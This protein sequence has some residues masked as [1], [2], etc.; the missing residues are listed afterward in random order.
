MLISLFG[1]STE[2]EKADLKSLVGDIEREHTTEAE[3]EKSGLE[4]T[5]ETEDEGEKDRVEEEEHRKLSLE[6]SEEEDD[7]LFGSDIEETEFEKYFDQQE[8]TRGRVIF[9]DQERFQHISRS[10]WNYDNQVYLVKLQEKLLGIDEV[11]FDSERYL[12]SRN[13]EA[14]IY[15]PLRVIRWRYNKSRNMPETNAR[16]IEWSDGSRHLAI[17]NKV[18]VDLEDRRET[19]LSYIFEDDGGVMFSLGKVDRRFF[20]QPAAL[21]PTRK[22]ISMTTQRTQ[23]VKWL[24]DVE[25]EKVQIEE[26]QTQ[27]RRRT[28]KRRRAKLSEAFLEDEDTA[29]IGSIK[30]RILA[31]EDISRKRADREDDEAKRLLSAK[32]RWDKSDED[33]E[34]EITDNDD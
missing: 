33:D 25:R 8:S 10:P 1:A 26:P 16:I 30:K 21:L 27:P 3:G 29:D 24:T 9:D 20:M 31:G 28:T 7:D 13:P 23:R 2:E 15:D 4:G 34:I 12:K 32:K 5:V 6:E 22:P 18:V 19:S 11:P 17:G 14:S